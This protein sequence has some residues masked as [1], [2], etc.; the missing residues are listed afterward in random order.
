MFLELARSLSR[1]AIPLRRLSSS[2]SFTCIVFHW[3]KGPTHFKL[4]HEAPWLPASC[5]ITWLIDCWNKSLPLSSSFCNFFESFE[6]FEVFYVFWV[7][8][9]PCIV[10]RSLRFLHSFSFFSVCILYLYSFFYIFQRSGVID[11]RKISHTQSVQIAS[12]CS[13]IG[14]WQAHA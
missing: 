13:W 3:A 9:C 6:F 4:R 14:A 7:L 11:H 10:C 5:L 1:M 8:W 2:E 12:Y